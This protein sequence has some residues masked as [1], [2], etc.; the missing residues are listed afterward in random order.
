MKQDT[1]S[2]SG[3]I[4]VVE[5]LVPIVEEVVEQR[6]QKPNPNSTNIISAPIPMRDFF[7]MVNNALDDSDAV[8]V[9]NDAG[10]APTSDVCSPATVDGITLVESFWLRP[11]GDIVADPEDT[12]N[13]C[14]VAEYGIDGG[15]IDLSFDLST[16]TD[17]I[18]S[19]V[20]PRTPL[21]CSSSSCIETDDASVLV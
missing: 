2:T 6:Y 19:I 16:L 3:V 17:A 13:L 11:T 10:G 15:S 7:N 8:V 1:N 18:L 4:D 14:N 12:R 5:I 21:L 20:L 9:A